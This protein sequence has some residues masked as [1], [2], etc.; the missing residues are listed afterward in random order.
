MNTKTKFHAALFLL[1]ILLFTGPVSGQT[2]KSDSAYIFSL[3]DKAEGFYLDSKYDS[4]LFYSYKAESISRQANFKK[5]IAYALIKL[6]DVYLD[7]EDFEKATSTATTVNAMGLQM[8][9]SLVAAIGWMQLA[10]AK[11]YNDKFTEAIDLFAK[12]L[13]Y[14]LDKHQTRYTALAFNDLGYS[15]GRLGELSKQANCI[16]RSISIYENYFPEEYGE[17]GVAYNNLS[18]VYYSLN[19][20]PKAIDYAKKSIFYREKDGDIKR[21]SLGC[22]NLSQYYIGI[23]NEEAKKYQQLCLKYAQQSNEEGRI[24]HSYVTASMIANT[25]K[26]YKESADYELKAI[27]MLEKTNKDIAMLCRRYISLASNYALM[28]E[29]SSK[30][31]L[32][33]NKAIGLAR[34]PND[35]FNIR[36]VYA[37]LTEYY[38]QQQQYDKALDTYQQYIIYRDSIVTSN[39]KSAIADIEAKYKGEKKDKEIAD[40]SA[41][42][43]IK[44]LQ[45]EKQK[46]VIS[47]NLLEAQK[48]EKEIELLS[49]ARELQDLKIQ[50][51]DEQLEKQLLLAK[52]NQQQLQLAEKE[53]QLRDK[54]LKSSSQL[55]NF[56]LIGFG[57]LLLLGYFMFNRYQLQRKIKEQQSLLAVRNNIAQDLHDEIGSALTSI[58]ILSQVSKTNLHKDTNKT[59][60]FLEKITE[61]STEMQQGLSDIVWAIKPDNDKL[62]NMVVRMREYVSH[63]LEPKNIETGFLIDE[64]LLNRSL[65]MQQRRDL[66]LVFKEA[67][68]NIAKYSNCTRAE[69][70]L[71]AV[72]DHIQLDISD[73]GV[74]FDVN[75]QTS[76]NGLKNMKARALALGGELFIRSV[77]GNGTGL[78]L[79]I[80]AT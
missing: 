44:Q 20:R 4:A 65:N 1:I 39:T 26:N 49:N 69:I 40:L 8:N 30:V 9:D 68:N 76:S 70:K 41:A 34:Q 35:K 14:Y 16:T 57:L 48:K 43:K 79:N 10:Q 23:D 2:N 50:Q 54:Q 32:C 63:T 22:C 53:K 17:L 62:S 3:L 27:N 42:Q 11:M 31:L 25:Q 66:L 19:D 60:S 6:T 46:A 15:W 64:Q 56:L 61:Q 52:N 5:G 13:Q 24:I 72:N 36:D 12:C 80:P 7:K 51:Q 18:M 45:I 55:R 77:I 75:K 28:G 37:K 59:S 33:F 73:N 21:L 58:K 38:R 47:G 71:V 78:Q 67:V 74:G 29:D